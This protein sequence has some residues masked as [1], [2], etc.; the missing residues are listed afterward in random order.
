MKKKI[1]GIFV[2]TLLIATAYSSVG[3]EENTSSSFTNSI[4]VED[5]HNPYDTPI[6]NDIGIDNTDEA[7]A[8][9]FI[10]TQTPL[11]KVQL[12]V[13]V[14]GNPPENTN[15]MLSIRENL[16]G[17]DIVSST[18]NSDDFEVGDIDFIFPD[19]DLTIGMTYYIVL[20]ADK[21]GSYGNWHLWSSS[22]DTYEN[23]ELWVYAN[24]KWQT[25]EEY[26]GRGLDLGFTTYWRDYGP[27][28]P[29]IDG[30]TEGK[31]QEMIDYTFSANDPEGHDVK[32]FIEWGDG[33]TIDLPGPYESGEIVTESHS[34]ENKDTYTIRVIA[35]DVYGADSDWTE[36]EISMPKAK[37]VNSP[38]LTFLQNHPHLFP[39]LRQILGL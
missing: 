8:Q 18:I 37:I 32:F 15:Y 20:T 34:W 30:P 16:D 2:M 28:D 11:T 7:F 23:G 21:Q 24:N 4:E 10:P 5:Q 35:E 27:D 31:A 6:E 39:L 13:Y 38:F 19:T 12:N 22:Y 26:T 33:N 9:T 1:V 25:V 36:L 3:L 17:E 29:E 14:W